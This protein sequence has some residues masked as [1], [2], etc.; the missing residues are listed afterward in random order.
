M[1][2]VGA[3]AELLE[4]EKTN[5]FWVR[6]HWKRGIVCLPCFHSGRWEC[7]AIYFGI[8]RPSRCGLLQ[9]PDC[10]GWVVTAPDT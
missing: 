1:V 8:M 10:P 6:L 7:L 4:G 9:F 3:H 5:T 2:P